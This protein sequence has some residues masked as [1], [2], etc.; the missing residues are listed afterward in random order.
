MAVPMLINL[1]LSGF[2]FCGTD[3]GGFQFDCTPELLSRW[4]QLGCFTPLFRNHS[5]VNTRDQEPWAFDEKT[6][7][8]NRRYIKLRYKLLPY[9]YDL[10]YQSENKGLPIMRPLFMHYM[11]DKNT[12]EL[13]DEFLFGE[14]ILVAPILEQ[15]KNFRAVYL[16]EGVWYDYWTGERLEGKRL[17]LKEAPID[18]CP[19][20]I[21]AGSII[22]TYEEMDYIG[23]KELKEVEFEVYRGNGSYVHYEDDRETFNYREGK[24]NLYKIAQFE[25]ENVLNIQFSIEYKGFDMGYKN[26]KFRLKNIKASNVKVNDVEVKPEVDGNDTVISLGLKNCNIKLFI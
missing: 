25:Q 17:V 7:E 8:I 20:Y 1:G 2:A 21:K 4:V 16:P 18:I 24:Y 23:E 19:I 10:F 14:N 12:Y 15:G 11:N 13:N 3:V 6:E 5:C 9:L 22:P 26:I